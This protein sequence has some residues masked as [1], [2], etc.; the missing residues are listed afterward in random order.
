MSKNYNQ[1]SLVQRYQIE[2]FLKAGMK[3]NF[4]AEQIG[5]HPATISRELRR[6]IAKRGRTSGDYVAKNAQRKTD[7][8][9]RSKPKLVKFTDKMKKQAVKWLS[10]DKWSPELISVIGNRTGKCPISAE[11][12]YQWIWD[13]KKGNSSKDKPIKT[14]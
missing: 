9:H 5:V 12:I 7:N 3:Q 1:L 4:I 10:E 11:W 8:R 14:I 2:A 6:N 13:S